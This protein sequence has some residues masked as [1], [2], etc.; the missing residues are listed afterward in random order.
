MKRELKEAA[1]Y[2]APFV[3]WIALQMALPA[4]AA[5][6]AIRAAATAAVGLACLAALK[7]PKDI[8]GANGPDGL[9]K[10][11]LPLSRQALAGLA[12][13]LLVCALWIAPE[14]SGWYRTWLELPI[15]VPPPAPGP[16]PYEPSACGWPLTVAKL[17]GSAFVIAPAEEVFFRSFLYRRLQAEDFRAVPLSRFDISS[18]LWTVFLFTLEHDRPVVA[19]IA[20]AAYGMLAI[21]LG[22]FAA[23][24]A[25]V[26]TNLALGLHVICWGEWWF[27]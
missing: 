24:V 9:R 14:Y 2:A 13:G 5:G 10:F 12:G 3:T 25:H 22:L 23:I 15:G 4:T 17:V 11:A 27:W 21:R 26:A 16:S 19:A 20:G 1:L 7:G 8:K 6:Y 18:F